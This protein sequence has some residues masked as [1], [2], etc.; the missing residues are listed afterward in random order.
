[1]AKNKKTA[2]SDDERGFKRIKEQRKPIKNFKTHLK[3]VAQA[4]LDEDDFD[5]EDGIYYRK[6]DES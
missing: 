6:R 5:Y 4:Y 2:Q 1:M 3:D